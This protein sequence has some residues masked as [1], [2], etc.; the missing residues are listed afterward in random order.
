[1][2]IKKWRIVV[3]ILIIST[4]VFIF[5]NSL[6]PV[7]N[8]Q[9]ESSLALVFVKPVLEL[10]IN[11][12]NITDHLV[13]KM[14]HFTEFFVLGF[15]LLLFSSMLKQIKLQEVANC[16]SIALASAVTDEA[17]QMLTLGRGPLVS[18]VLLD[19]IG[20]CIGILI[21]LAINEFRI[22]QQGKV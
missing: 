12:V 11:N 2:K 1:M 18:D 21:M 8:S 5:G 22:W 7:E 14:A 19:F 15:E 13:R 17:L 20:A 10:F 4:Y 9:S 6:Q 16:L 3:L